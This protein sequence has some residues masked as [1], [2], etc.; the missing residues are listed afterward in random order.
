MD[1]SL[2]R[3]TRKANLFKLELHEIIDKN[4]LIHTKRFLILQ[5]ILMEG[6]LL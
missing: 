4:K 6:C 1:I 3:L 5:Q 2:S